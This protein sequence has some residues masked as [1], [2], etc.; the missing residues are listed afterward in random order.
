M[1]LKNMSGNATWKLKMDLERR[2]SSLQPSIYVSH[3]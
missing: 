1:K 3:I 2:S